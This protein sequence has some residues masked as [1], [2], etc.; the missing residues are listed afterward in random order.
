[1]SY[2][3]QKSKSGQRIGQARVQRLVTGFSCEIRGCV[4]EGEWYVTFDDRAFH[5]CSAHITERM[6]NNKFWDSQVKRRAR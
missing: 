4:K 5:W 1:M 6:H 3:D 2:E